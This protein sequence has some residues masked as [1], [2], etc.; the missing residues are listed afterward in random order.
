MSWIE[1]KLLIVNFT[2]LERDALHIYGALAI[3]CVAAFA[4]RK[5]LSS[6]WPWMI[7]LFFALLNEWLDND[8]ITNL[9]TLSKAASE[10]S[11]KDM[12][13]TML[14]PT[15]LMLLS[16]FF[17]FVLVQQSQDISPQIERNIDD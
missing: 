2:G 4:L 6:L 12:C 16:R 1:F 3:Q 11:Y 9:S 5:S 13:N 8:Q 17:P 15:M 7:V 14:T 10:E